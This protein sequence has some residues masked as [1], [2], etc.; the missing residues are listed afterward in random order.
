MSKH[1]KWIFRVDDFSKSAKSFGN[2]CATNPRGDASRGQRGR[3]LIPAAMP[4][5]SSSPAM[6]SSQQS[7][8]Y[9]FFSPIST[10]GSSS[11]PLSEST[12]TP[13][14]TS[15]RHNVALPANGQRSSLKR[16]RTSKCVPSASPP[17]PPLAKKGRSSPPAGHVSKPSLSH[18]A[19]RREPRATIPRSV[20]DRSLA[21]SRGS[22]SSCAISVS[23]SLWW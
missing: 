13:L 6:P 7:S 14:G 5:P 10:T 18:P 22:L 19:R 17:D 9:D 11:T 20:L 15:T 23:S 3:G 1:W 16:R 21:G 8:L 4:T 12:R 2:D